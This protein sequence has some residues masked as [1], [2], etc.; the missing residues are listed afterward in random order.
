MSVLPDAPMCKKAWSLEPVPVHWSV[1]VQN[2]QPCR[3]FKD[4]YVNGYNSLHKPDPQAAGTRVLCS[5][6][7]EFIPWR[8]KLELMD[9]AARAQHSRYKMLETAGTRS[10]V[11]FWKMFV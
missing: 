1:R 2:R 11:S 10:E 5:F 9:Y 6:R 7:T 8:W 4:N 3:Y